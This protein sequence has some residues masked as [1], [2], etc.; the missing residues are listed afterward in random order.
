[1]LD[2]SQVVAMEGF[3]KAAIMWLE[4]ETPTIAIFINSAWMVQDVYSTFR[5]IFTK[6]FDEYFPETKKIVQ[7]ML[8]A[9]TSYLMLR[10]MLCI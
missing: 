5:D 10:Y 2:H 8:K 7:K 6:T 4:S 3:F 9:N 1:M